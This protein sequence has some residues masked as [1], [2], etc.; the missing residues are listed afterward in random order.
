MVS[1]HL[2]PRTA[3]HPGRGPIHLDLSREADLRWPEPRRITKACR[4]LQEA[5]RGSYQLPEGQQVRATVVLRG[6]GCPS[7]T[8]PP[9]SGAPVPWRSKAPRRWRRREDPRAFAQLR[10]LRITRHRARVEGTVAMSVA[11]RRALPVALAPARIDLPLHLAGHQPPR[12]ILGRILHGIGPTALRRRVERWRR[13]VGH[14]ALRPVSRVA[15]RDVPRGAA[16]AQAGCGPR[17]VRSPAPPRLRL[18]TSTSSVDAIGRDSSS[19]VP[20]W[21]GRWTAL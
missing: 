18:Q 15:T 12:H 8:R 14:R 6:D 21:M 13:V 2:R 5:V 16:T 9:R 17:H 11:Q 10:G 19:K 4:T 3:G 1:A 7:S 20:R